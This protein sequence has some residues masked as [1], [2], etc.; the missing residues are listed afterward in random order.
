[1]SGFSLHTLEQNKRRISCLLLCLSMTGLVAPPVMA[2]RVS[3]DLPTCD[4]LLD[5]DSPITADQRRKASRDLSPLKLDDGSQVVEVGNDGRLKGTVRESGMAAQSSFG[6]NTALDGSTQSLITGKTQDSLG[7]KLLKDAKTV[8][9][10]PL[11]LVPS[12]SEANQKQDTIVQLEQAQLTE[13]WQATIN[14]SP[15]IQFVVSRLQPNTDSSHATSSAVKMLSTALFGAMQTAPYVLG[16]GSPMMFMG[17]SSG[18]GIIQGLFDTQN[19]KQQKQQ[20]ISQEQAT[21]LYKIVRETA[22]RVVEKYRGYKKTNSSLSRANKDLAE[23]KSMVADGRIGQDPGKA[24]EMEYTLRKQQRDIDG[25]GDE[26]REKRQS[27]IDMAGQ[28]AVAHLDQQMQE[29]QEMLHK[30]TGADPDLIQQGNPVTGPA[31]SATNSNFS[32]PQSVGETTSKFG[33]SL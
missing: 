26:I 28:D 33:K 6:A 16:Q 18:A 3:F 19:K 1:M 7:E 12:E 25:L 20:Q 5:G 22:E 23:L 13:L 32:L 11:A 30:L 9:A 8:N 27:L 4:K 31:S 2:K 21:M 17:A 15:D 24:I 29:E 14:R 10:M